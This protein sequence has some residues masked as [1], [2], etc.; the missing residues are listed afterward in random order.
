MTATLCQNCEHASQIYSKE[1]AD[2]FG[3]APDLERT[4]FGEP[5]RVSGDKCGPDAR[6]W[7]AKDG[8]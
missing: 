1:W 4:A 2:R 7:K 6:H 5:F 8:S 3:R